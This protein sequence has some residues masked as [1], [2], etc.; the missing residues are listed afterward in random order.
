MFDFVN[1]WFG[2]FGFFFVILSF[3]IYVILGNGCLIF[4]GIFLFW[5]WYSRQPNILLWDSLFAEEGLELEGGVRVVPGKD[6]GR[7]KTT[8]EKVWRG[9]SATQGSEPLPL[10]T[11]LLCRWWFARAGSATM[12]SSQC[13]FQVQ[14]ETRQLW[15]QVYPL[16]TRPWRGLLGLDVINRSCCDMII[17]R[18]VGKAKPTWLSL[19]DALQVS[20]CAWD[21]WWKAVQTS[22]PVYILC[23]RNC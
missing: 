8:V 14:G 13:V 19:G 16:F 7:C 10:T 2:C 22:V 4:Q 5:K 15:Q 23:S 17:A 21:T 1:L 12:P 3:S 20:N 9:Y 18:S 11:A 6:A